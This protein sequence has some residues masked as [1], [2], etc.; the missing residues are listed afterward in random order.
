M[1][2]VVAALEDK[3]EVSEWARKVSVTELLANQ[4]RGLRVCFAGTLV[5]GTTYVDIWVSLLVLSKMMKIP[6][7]A[8]HLVECMSVLQNMYYLEYYEKCLKSRTGSGFTREHCLARNGAALR[9][10]KIIRNPGK[11]K[12]L[13][14]LFRLSKSDLASVGVPWPT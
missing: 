7:I 12:R 2:L 10:R 8:E 9:Q 14:K 1:W 6:E 11:I 4:S 5:A 13:I 3:P